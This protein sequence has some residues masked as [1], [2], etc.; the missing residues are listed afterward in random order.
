MN[1]YIIYLAAGNSRRFGTNKLLYNYN[2]KPLYRYGFDLLT[3]FCEKHSDC[4]L[5]VISQYPEIL[6]YAETAGARAVYSPDSCKGMSYTIKTA[7]HAL[8]DV[9]EEDFILFVVADQPY[10]TEYTLERILEHAVP[11]VKTVSASY[12]GNAGNPTMF[13]ARLIPELLALQK[14]QGGR[15]V[16]RTHTCI[17]VDAGDARELHD[18]DTLQNF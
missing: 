3:S 11:G 4:L 8:K 12:G 1:K 2:G 13:S 14:D 15:K 10:L 18:I 7:I 6:E 5:T 17:Y 9:K 16:I